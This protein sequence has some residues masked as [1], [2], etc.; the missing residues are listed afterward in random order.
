MVLLICNKV[1]SPNVPFKKGKGFVSNT[2]QVRMELNTQFPFRDKGKYLLTMQSGALTK[3]ARD[4]V[5]E[6]DRS[7]KRHKRKM[8]KGAKLPIKH[9]GAGGPN[10]RVEARRGGGYFLGFAAGQTPGPSSV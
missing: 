3:R 5:Q 8:D 7:V 4:K 9:A 6:A 2:T 1:V 10:G